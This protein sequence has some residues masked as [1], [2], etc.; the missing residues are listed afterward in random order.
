MSYGAQKRFSRHRFLAF[1]RKETLQVMREGAEMRAAINRGGILLGLLGD[2]YA[3]CMRG[4][5][6]GRECDT[7]LAPAVLAL[8]YDCQLYTAFCFRTALAQWRLE[9]GDEIATHENGQ[10][11][12][13]AAIM[14]DVNAS[15][16]Q[17]I[18]RDPANWFWVHNRWKIRRPKK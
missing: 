4:P 16:E 8:R 12:S 2:Q 3:V 14:A 18:R 6:L 15:Y 17:A 5:F 9:L 10:P 1:M 11:R 7:G 13:T